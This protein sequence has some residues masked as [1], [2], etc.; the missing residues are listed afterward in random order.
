[1]TA[2]PG[3]TGPVLICTKR[4]ETVTGAF[5]GMFDML[6]VVVPVVGASPCPAIGK[7]TLPTGAT[8]TRAGRVKK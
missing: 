6:A 3:T 2:S 5:A 7:F 8:A 4:A 1:M